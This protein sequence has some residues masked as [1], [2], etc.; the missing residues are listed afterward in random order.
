MGSKKGEATHVWWGFGSISSLGY[1][2]VKAYLHSLCAHMLQWNS[3]IKSSVKK[4]IE[5]QTS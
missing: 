2:Y 3:A 5:L 1:A 4:K